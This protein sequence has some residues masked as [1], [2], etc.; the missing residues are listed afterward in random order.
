M[1]A[2]SVEVANRE[3]CR[4][5]QMPMVNLATVLIGQRYRVT[6]TACFTASVTST[7]QSIQGLAT[8]GQ[9]EMK[10]ISKHLATTGC[11]QRTIAIEGK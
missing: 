11:S 3:R 6:S 1:E 10:Q 5:F 4:R 8:L 7:T 9:K 2:I